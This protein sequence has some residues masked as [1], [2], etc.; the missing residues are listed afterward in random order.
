MTD[1]YR[2]RRRQGFLDQ[3]Q[4]ADGAWEEAEFTG[5]GFPNYFYKLSLLRV[6]LLSVFS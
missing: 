6:C 4:N 2:P 3:S 1:R 5:A